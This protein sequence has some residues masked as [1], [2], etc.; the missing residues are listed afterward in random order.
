MKIKIKK[1]V[2][3]KVWTY[4]LSHKIL[5]IIIILAA[6]MRLVGDYPGYTPFHSDEGMSY[7]GAITMFERLNFDPGRYDYPSLIPI[8]NFFI[9]LFFLIPIYILQTIFLHPDK[10]PHFKNLIDLWQLVVLK[11]QQTMVLF[12]GRYI[13]A[14][15]GVGGVIMTYYVA[16]RYFK[17]IKV[18]LGAAFLTA[19]NYRLVLNSHF[20]LPDIYN[21]FMLLINFYYLPNLLKKPTLKTYLISF[22]LLALF[23]S[24]KFQIF[25][26]APLIIIHLINLFK[27]NKKFNLRKIIFNRLNFYAIMG[28]L[29]ALFVV[30]IINYTHLVH[31]EEFIKIT[32]YNSLKY[33]VGTNSL[34]FYS[35]SYLFHTGLGALIFISVLGG[36]VLGIKKYRLNSLLLL[37]VVIPFFALLIYFTR[38]GFYTRNYVTITSVLLIFASFFLVSVA[39]F[40]IKILKLPKT[41]LPVVICLSLILSSLDQIQKSLIVVREYQKPWNLEL[42]RNWLA[43]NALNSAT[44]VSHPWDPYPRDKEFNI[45][46]YQRDEILTLSEVQDEK[47][48]FAF[49]G[50]DWL[51]MPFYWWM[52]RS[53]LESLSYWNKPVDILAN[54]VSSVV[55]QEFAAYSSAEFIKPAE[56]PD[57]NFLILKIRPKKIISEKK[58]L[59]S[60]KFDKEKD[61]QEWF[62]IDG[63]LDI[64]NKIIWS[65]QEGHQNKGSVFFKEGLNDIP[66]YRITSKLIPIDNKKAIILKGFIKTDK[67]LTK[68]KREGF[69]RIDFYDQDPGK[70]TYQTRSLFSSLGSRVYRTNDWVEQI[71]T[72]V[73]PKNSRYVSVGMQ[74]N[75]ST[76]TNIFLDD[77]TVYQST[78][79]WNELGLIQ[80]DL[81]KK[82]P[83]DV[84]FPNS[85]GG[86]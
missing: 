44:I 39:N 5:V 21:G 77:L 23:F 55:A 60:F 3:K 73:P 54:T 50:M 15:F 37:S 41:I 18:A 40:I 78:K 71:V 81:D 20:G 65:G 58:E 56:T 48:D 4:F 85:H 30:L 67:I 29:L 57:M 53:T 24:T 59:M 1:R 61:F 14:V 84:L 10:L 31:W 64:S 7:S 43:E 42:A 33:G 86:L 8:I 63:R 34:N 45:I 79:N 36:L 70:I 52:N 35:I 51:N 11:N 32:S 69:L 80:P 66:V 68:K 75:E 19:V 47:A 28:G 49:L 13:T 25:P 72:V 46:P 76:T 22:L 74:I 2:F 26:I 16:K 27:S 6:W 38:G 17:D 12:W 82:I 62:A 9:Y 83:E